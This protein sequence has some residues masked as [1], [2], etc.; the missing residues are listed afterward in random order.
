M[1]NVT[2]PTLR[3]NSLRV[4]CRCDNASKCFCIAASPLIIA[5]IV[6][7]KHGNIVLMKRP[8]SRLVLGF[9]LLSGLVVAQNELTSASLYGRSMY[10]RCSYNDACQIS[11]ATI[12]NVS[13]TVEPTVDGVITIDEDEVNVITN[14]SA[15]YTMTLESSSATENSL[16][17]VVDELT[18][19]SGTPASPSVLTGNE[20]GYRIDDFSGFGAGPTSAV[21]N[22]PSSSLTF[23]GMPLLG[24]AAT[25][26]TTSSSATLGD[27]TY[28]WYGARA[29]FGVAPDTYTQTVLYTVVAL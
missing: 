26:K 24:S 6:I 27:T 14:S 25:I 5:T 19:V 9:V 23:A 2:K 21:T 10:G 12:S 17:G 13:L 8:L 11:I 22:Q 28:V 29:D 20:W 16:E 4:M 15:G 7:H 3:R 1:D 18:A